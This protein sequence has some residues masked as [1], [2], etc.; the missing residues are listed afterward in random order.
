MNS[1]EIDLFLRSQR[2]VVVVGPA[3]QGAPIAAVGRFFYDNGRVGFALRAAHPVVGLLSND[4]RVCCV[5]ERFPS[6]HEIICVMLHG[7]AIPVSGGAQEVVFNLE[8]DK[9]VSFDFAKL[10][11]SG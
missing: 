6:Y 2:R 8:I 7:H 4:D 1:E 5:L 11:G 3:A 10:V 9:V